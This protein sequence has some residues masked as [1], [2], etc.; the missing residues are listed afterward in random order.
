[1]MKHILG[2]LVENHPGVLSKVSGLFSRRGFNIYSLAVGMTEDPTVSR[3][4][5]VV[6]GDSYIV[7]QVIKQLNKL[8]DVIKVSKIEED[9][10]TRE[11][12]LIKVK[13]E[14][15]TRHQIV[16]LINIFRAQV[17][18]INKNHLIVEI[19]GDS[20]KIT[21]LVDMLKDYG[22]EEMVRT[23]AIAI[24]RGKRMLKDERNKGGYDNGNNVL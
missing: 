4:T 21:A 12:A 23:G 7:E 10:L 17:V 18:D 11:L 20:E 8:I 16:E 3:I 13:A 6:E 19:T 1:M 14:P 24:N 2:V 5:I 15:N 9:S 22:I